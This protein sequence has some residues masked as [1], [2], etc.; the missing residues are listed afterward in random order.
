[1]SKLTFV[2]AFGVATLFL[3]TTSLGDD[4]YKVKKDTTSNS[5]KSKDTSSKSSSSPK[6]TSSK[7]D[8][9]SSVSHSSSTVHPHSDTL[10]AL[11]S[12]PSN[13]KTFDNAKPK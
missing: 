11:K 2:L 9:S 12:S 10:D 4:T 3:A 5:S 8:S 7:S 13:D 1:M 6:S